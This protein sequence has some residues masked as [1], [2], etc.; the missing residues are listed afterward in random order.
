MNGISD[1]LA[2]LKSGIAGP[3]HDRHLQSWLCTV[4]DQTIDP[5]S[6]L[7][8][9][10]NTFVDSPTASNFTSGEKV[11]A[12][13]SAN[14]PASAADAPRINLDRVDLD[15]A[16]TDT[17]RPTLKAARPGFSDLRNL[18]AAEVPATGDLL[19]EIYTTVE[20]TSK[21]YFSSLACGIAKL[22]ETGDSSNGRLA[23]PRITGLSYQGHLTELKLT[24]V[25][26]DSE[27]PPT[28]SNKAHT[29]PSA[30]SRSS[31][32]PQAVPFI[33]LATGNREST[34]VA[35]NKMN[36]FEDATKNVKPALKVGLE[37]S[38][39][40]DKPFEHKRKASD[41]NESYAIPIIKP[42]APKASMTL[43]EDKIVSAMAMTEPAKTLIPDLAT[44]KPVDAQVSVSAALV[45]HFV[46]VLPFKPCSF[47]VFPGTEM[48]TLTFLDFEAKKSV[49][50]AVF[51]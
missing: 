20:D 39:W 48:L 5:S 30:S 22:T 17:T 47:D 10:H 37:H 19:N 12:S 28:A 31:L 14:D 43:G 25:V 24:S 51:A 6:N 41:S 7:A 21:C 13:A 49:P 18:S 26:S 33:F 32:N 46:P 3:K 1:A 15:Q 38:M 29:T 4:Q 8:L 40:A 44:E 36:P 50:K 42:T 2:S 45:A 9:L 16:A 27:S 11:T 34:L 23:T 35:T